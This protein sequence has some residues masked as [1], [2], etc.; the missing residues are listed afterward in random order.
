MNHPQ[1]Q[2][3]P[4][5]LE[6]LRITYLLAEQGDP[7]DPWSI[8]IGASTS[9]HSLTRRINN[10]QSGNKR[11]LVLVA[12]LARPEVA[13]SVAERF[14]SA[15]IVSHSQAGYDLEQSLLNALY[16]VRVPE[17]EWVEGITAE[18]ILALAVDG[19]LP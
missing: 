17:T 3:L 6:Q 14:P 11:R 18:E 5:N 8:K 7:E 19:V 4:T 1:E 12:A 16:D 10:L 2:Q 15:T 9:S 13:D